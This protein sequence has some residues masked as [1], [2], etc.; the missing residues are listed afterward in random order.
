MISRDKAVALVARCNDQGITVSAVTLDVCQSV[1]VY[2]T[3]DISSSRS[4]LQIYFCWRLGTRITQ[5]SSKTASVIRGLPWAQGRSQAMRN[6]SW[7]LVVAIIV[8]GCGWLALVWIVWHLRHTFEIAARSPLLVCIF[9]VAAL[10]LVL[11]VLV[12]WLILLE[13][14]RMPCYGIYWTSYLGEL[15]SCCLVVLVY[16]R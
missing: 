1:S 15:A 5:Q 11:S 6:V 3:H 12:H 9:E 7:C 10:Q 16:N 4:N 8:V 2:T 13:G 14:G